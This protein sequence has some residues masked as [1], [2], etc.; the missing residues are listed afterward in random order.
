[1]EDWSFRGHVE[2]RNQPQKPQKRS[3]HRSGC[4][5]R[6]RQRTD[7]CSHAM[8]YLPPHFTGNTVPG[9]GGLVISLRFSEPRFRFRISYF[10]SEIR[11]RSGTPGFSRGVG[12]VGVESLCKVGQ[13]DRCSLH[14]PNSD[15]DFGLRHR[16]PKSKSVLVIS[17]HKND[18]NL[19]RA[20]S[21]GCRFQ[22]A[23]EMTFNAQTHVPMQ[24]GWHHHETLHWKHGSGSV[25]S[26]LP[27]PHNP[28]GLLSVPKLGGAIISRPC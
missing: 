14:F 1:M 10:G 19:D 4:S 11:S 13:S 24:C 8:W 17:E 5:T 3:K 18:R 15:F 23:S 9:R 20:V 6:L 28:L 2:T 12:S 22:H 7:P 21:L 16:N 26:T 25:V 27:M